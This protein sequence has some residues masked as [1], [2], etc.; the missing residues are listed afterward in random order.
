LITGRVVIDLKVQ[1]RRTGKIVCY[2]RQEAT[3][4]DLGGSVARSVA[5]IKAVEELAARI[6]PLLAK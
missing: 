5:T 4:I 6:V 3:A 1:E 2:D